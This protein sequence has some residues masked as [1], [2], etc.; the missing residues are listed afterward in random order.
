MQPDAKQPVPHP[1]L[2]LDCVQAKR[3]FLLTAA[4]GALSACGGGGSGNGSPNVPSPSPQTP[5]PGLQATPVAPSTPSPSKPSL[6]QA[7]SFLQQASFSSTLGEIA[8]VQTLGYTAWIEH[9][10]NKPV[11]ESC[12]DWLIAHGF[13]DY[14]KYRFSVG[15]VFNAVWKRLIASPDALRQRITLALSEVFVAS[16]AGSES[17]YYPQFFMAA[18]WDML[19]VKAFGNYRELLESVTLSIAMG[20]CLNTAGNQK[21]DVKTGRQPDENYA[22]E[23]LQLFSIG[24]Y[25]LNPDGTPKIDANGQPLESYS[26]DDISQLARVFTGWNVP[27]NPSQGWDYAR[28]PMTFN[29]NQH[30]TLEARFLGAVVPAN[31]DGI[32]ALRIALDAI[33]THPNVGPFLG[34]QLIQRLVTS[35]PGPAYVARVAAAFADNGKGVRG[36]MRAVISAVLLDDEARNDRKLGTPNF[37]K[38]R[39]PILRLVQWARSFN[40]SS[41]DD[42]WRIGDLSGILGQQPLKSPTVFNFFRPGYVPPNTA[43]ADQSMVAPE[44][45]I[46]DESSIPAYMNF[47]QGVIASGRN[48]VRANYSTELGMIQDPDALMQHLNLVLCAGQM[49][50]STL[51][52]I[53][54]AINTIS[55]SSDRGRSNRLSAAIFMTM[56]CPDYLIQQ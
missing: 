28:L 16:T 52:A 14:D 10:F 50:S 49:A 54:D 3:L 24:L 51:N 9:E 7:A 18:W 8:S 36:D 30:S 56:C 22:R 32:S 20:L 13:T 35:N 41:T 38:L 31:T 29:S 34:K 17:G 2:T 26:Q 53:R 25:Q 21:E 37:G 48:G 12:W 45:Q 42:L 55:I 11:S 27:D 5:A 19:S 4:T 15:T 23:I 47:M 1:T 43:I 40:A 44:F 33:F 6:T 46:V 39:E